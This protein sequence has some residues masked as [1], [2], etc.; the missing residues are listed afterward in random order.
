[1]SSNLLV[2]DLGA[3]PVRV[4]LP[5]GPAVTVIDVLR[6]EAAAAPLRARLTRHG[7]MKEWGRFTPLE[8][9]ERHIERLDERLN[10][11]WLRRRLGFLRDPKAMRDRIR[12][13][14]SC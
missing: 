7:R 8:R 3:G 12:V 2:I 1:M 10:R 13:G 11:R 4:F 6:Y 5:E 14:R 9:L